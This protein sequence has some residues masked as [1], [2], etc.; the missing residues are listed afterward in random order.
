MPLRPTTG[1]MLPVGIVEKEMFH[2]CSHS[3]RKDGRAYCVPSLL[4]PASVNV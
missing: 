3:F 1:H 4:F 2:N